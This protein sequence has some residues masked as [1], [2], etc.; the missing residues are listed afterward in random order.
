MPAPDA[1]TRFSTRVENYVRHRPGYPPEI[2]GLLREKCGLTPQ[3]S[4]ADIGFGTGLFTRLLLENGNPVV[5]VEPNP[6]MRQAGEKFLTE[7]SNF[8][9][10]SGTAEATTLADRSMD[11]VTAAQ[12]AHWFD[13]EPT[14]REFARILKPGGWVVLVWNERITDGTPFLT[15]YEELLLRYGT[16]YAEVRHER[17]TDTIGGFFAPSLYQMETFP[18]QQTFDLAG[19][20]GRTFSSSYVPQ[21]GHPNYESI[22]RE[23]AEIFHRYAEDGKVAFEYWTRVFFGRLV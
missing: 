23:L 16:D 13:R 19:F 10:I 5:G 12:A 18:M 14:R 20:E 15:A 17:T 6:E 22:R 21:S 8:R 7:F 11:F 3:A 2:L 9:A 4:I 1:T